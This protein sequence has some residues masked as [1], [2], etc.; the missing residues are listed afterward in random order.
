[1]LNAI[2]AC[3]SAPTDRKAQISVRVRSLSTR[4]TLGVAEGTMESNGHGGTRL[5]EI[6]VADSGCGIPKEQLGRIWEP[7]VTSKP[8][9]TGLGLAIARQTVLAHRGNVV[10][11]STPGR[12][13]TI[14]F[15][16]PIDDAAESSD[17]TSVAT[18]ISGA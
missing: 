8:G 5:V 3:R 2:D 11:E 17:G 6:A 14:R 10:A 13:T 9:G 18:R 12:G 15:I 16:L 7:Y 1:M 4:G